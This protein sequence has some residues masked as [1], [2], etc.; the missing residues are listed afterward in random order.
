VYDATSQVA[1]LH[2]DPCAAA[3]GGEADADA[4]R[5]D[6]SCLELLTGTPFPF[7]PAVSHHH[8]QCIGRCWS[9][10]GRATLRWR[11]C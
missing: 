4:W 3:G 9:T 7:K 6:Y 5:E 1:G 8:I 10:A 2:G 11:N